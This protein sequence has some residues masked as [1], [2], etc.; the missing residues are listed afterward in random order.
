MSSVEELAAK[1]NDMFKKN[2]L[3]DIAF[4]DGDIKT[5]IS[6][7][8]EARAFFAKEAS[9]RG[10][11]P[12]D[13]AMFLDLYKESYFKTAP[14]VF[15]DYMMALE[16]KRPVRERFY[17]PRRKKL[18]VIVDAIQELVD[19][20]LDE[21]FISQPPRT[22]KT[23]LVLFL[24]TWLL[25]RDPEKANLYSAFSDTIT[26]AFYQ[27]ALEIINDDETYAWHKIFKNTEIAAKN[28]KLNTLDI[29]RKKRY[30]SLTCRSLYGT[31][32]GAC[33]CNGFLIS[34]DL[35]G[36]IEE[37]LNKDRMLSAWSKVDNN[38]LARAKM[39]AKIL[40]VGTRWSVVDPAGIRIDLLENDENYKNV[41]YKVINVPALD[42]E[43]ES[44]FDYDYGV[45]FST[46]YYRRRRASFERA[47]DL[48]SWLAQYQGEP[49]EREGVL[50]NV[51][52]LRFYNGVLPDEEPARRFAVVDV[53]WG[54]GDYLCMP[55]CYEYDN[56]ESYIVDAIFSQANKS[57]TQP[58]VANKIIQHKLGSVAIEGN[59]GGK[60]YKDAIEEL[61]DKKDY[62]CRLSAKNAPTTKAKSVRIFE[63]APDIV[64]FWFLEDGKRSKDYQQFI[65]NLLSFKILGKNKNDDAPD[66]MAQLVKAKYF[67][68]SV[69]AHV[70]NKS[71][72]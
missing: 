39:Q 7:V 34:D 35:I 63:S 16:S 10:N 60:E 27:G 13:R 2:E 3:A 47:G 8:R 58:L 11:N 40:W 36:G 69:K 6:L 21:L 32:N 43:D 4:A 57:I 51:N 5:G 48:A 52:D 45:G 18:K 9:N 28:S 50:F 12:D 55:I 23:T 25:G 67:G 64:E 62:K 56:G 15:E 65:Q 71:Y 49:I 38:L 29:K 54:G 26:T 72:F 1:T 31:L 68:Q 53:A 41:R 59:N 61:L 22:G 30:P 66:A 37:A 44:N 70:T 46:D 33:D 20:E 24:A 19:D 14:Y 17:Q 42:G